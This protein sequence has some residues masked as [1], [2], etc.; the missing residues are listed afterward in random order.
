MYKYHHQTQLK[1]PKENLI[2]I[3]RIILKVLLNSLKAV[4]LAKTSLKKLKVKQKH[5]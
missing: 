2:L 1:Q 5:L 4:P 3:F